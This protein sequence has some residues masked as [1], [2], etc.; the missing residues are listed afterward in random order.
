LETVAGDKV[1]IIVTMSNVGDD[2]ATDLNMDVLVD[3]KSIG[4][5]TYA[6]IAAGGGSKELFK[7]KAMKGVHTITVKVGEQTWTKDITVQKAPDVI[8]TTDIATYAL[9]LMIIIVAVALVS[10][11]AVVLRKK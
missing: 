1:D 7:W 9:P 6:D 8:S 3:G 11:G 10:F 5:K 4:T 2:N